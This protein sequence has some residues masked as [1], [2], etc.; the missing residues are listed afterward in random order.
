LGSQFNYH[1]RVAPLL[2]LLFSVPAA[3]QWVW[4]DVKLGAGGWVSGIDVHS[5]GTKVVRTDTYGGYI[6]NTS[7]SQWDQL[8][9][10]DSMPSGDG[11]G[12][13]DGNEQGIYEIKIDPQNSSTF[14]MT[15]DGYPWKSTNSGATWV[16]KDDA[17][18]TQ[19]TDMNANQQPETQRIFQDRLVIKPTD[20]DMVLASAAS[21]KIFRTTDGGTSWSV[22]TGLPANP[23][24]CDPNN[25]TVCDPYA[26]G[27][28]WGSGN[29]VYV[30]VQEEGVYKSTDSGASFFELLNSPSGG[31]PQ[32]VTDADYYGDKYIIMD[33]G[34]DAG[35]PKYHDGSDWINL[36]SPSPASR[37]AMI[38]GD[39]DADDVC[40]ADNTPWACC[41]AKDTGPCYR[42]GIGTGYGGL[43]VSVDNG[44]TW[45]TMQPSDYVYNQDTDDTRCLP[46]G[47]TSD[48]TNIGWHA[49]TNEIY[50]SAGGM[51]WDPVTTGRIWFSQGVGVWYQDFPTGSF[52]SS[53]WEEQSVGIEQ[54]V[55]LDIVA[56]PNETTVHFCAADRG[57]FSTSDPDAFLD[58]HGPSSSLNHCWDMDYARTDTSNPLIG[59]SSERNDA[60]YSAKTTDRGSTWVDMADYNTDP[61][62]YA[63][64]FAASTATNFIGYV[65]TSQGVFY[66]TDGGSTWGACEEIGTQIHEQVW[67][68][69]HV[70]TADSFAEGKFWVY[71]VDQDNCEGTPNILDGIWKT[72]NGGV[73]W[74]QEL[75]GYITDYGTTA[76]NCVADSWN[77]MLKSTP[78]GSDYTEH[79]W[80]TPMDIG[81]ADP[82][83]AGNF[84][85]STDGGANWTE[86]NANVAEVMAFG[87]GSK[88]GSYPRIYIAGWVSSVWGIWYSDDA[89]ATWTKVGDYP[90]GRFD[91]IAAV[92]GIKDGTE[93][94][95]VGFYGSGAVYGEPSG[96]QGWAG[97]G[98]A[99]GG[100]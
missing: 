28:V 25:V 6:W 8:V 84:Y 55:I 13:S 34:F 66:T 15:F 39:P 38:F 30:A 42:I 32:K 94:V 79:L 5:D 93:R 97:G 74:T 96:G 33:G 45:G 76:Q 44:A 62:V 56:P 58:A 90:M 29:D 10:V 2:A 16:R 27:M 36:G 77:G 91:Q 21:G 37:G 59:M 19:Q 14:W 72:T 35:T 86:P 85:R 49:F 3:A 12:G 50:M 80:W 73:D 64:G 87:F 43:M 78:G 88:F 46:D 31:E 63:G 99:G 70:L 71:A 9:T 82:S 61:N 7:T 26:A 95:Y 47:L 17:T 22:P 53:D 57:T 52:T 67:V 92:E 69:R 4:K 41:S 40:T 23:N 98:V 51:K 48:C 20:S 1:L 54:L 83:P 75:A 11:P 81:G 89:A 18:F 68:R 24:T 100:N 65:G 60:E